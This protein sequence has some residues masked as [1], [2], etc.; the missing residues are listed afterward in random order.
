MVS[1]LETDDNF[2]MTKYSQVNLGVAALKVCASVR[3]CVLCVCVYRYV[4]VCVCVC[5]NGDENGRR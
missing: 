1:G 5:V 4:C 2:F 3:V